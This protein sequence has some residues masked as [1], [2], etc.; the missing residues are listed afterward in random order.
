MTTTITLTLTNQEVNRL[1]TREIKDGVN[2]YEKLMNKVEYLIKLCQRRRAYAFISLYQMNE[3]IESLTQQFDED[4]D[5]YEEILQKKKHLVGKKITYYPRHFPEVVFDNTL[6]GSLIKLF[7]IYD[8]LISLIKTLRAVGCFAHDDEYFNTLRHYFKEV[9]RLLS[10]LLFHS[11]KKQ[12]SIRLDEAVDFEESY[13]PNGTIDYTLLYKAL[14]S[15]VAPRIQEKTRKP[16]ISL[17][18]R[19]LQAEQLLSLA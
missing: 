1:F 7:E 17:L 4:I 9:N 11:I 14:T 8:H 12:P 10:S 15:N 13:T 5:R 6:S 2:V 18:K 3:S 19:R 16:L